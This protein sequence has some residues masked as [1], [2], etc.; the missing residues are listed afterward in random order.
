MNRHLSSRFESAYDRDQA[1][2]FSAGLRSYLLK[3]YH[4]FFLFFARKGS[5]LDANKGSIFN[6]NLH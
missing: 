4:Y 1:L 6:T 2:E 3:V 5:S